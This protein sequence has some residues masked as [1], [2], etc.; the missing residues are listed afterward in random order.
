[1]IQH[2]QLEAKE[3]IDGAYANCIGQEAVKRKMRNAFGGLAHRKVF[4]STL[5]QS[6][7]GSGKT[8]FARESMAIIGKIR[9]RIHG[10]TEVKG[11]ELNGSE[12]SSKSAF[13]DIV[14]EK[15]C[16]RV[17]VLFVDEIHAASSKIVPILLTILA[18]NKDN[19][20]RITHDGKEFV[21]DFR[22]FSFLAA[23]TEPQELFPALRDRLREVNLIE[24]KRCELAEIIRIH[25]DKSAAI[26][27]SA[28]VEMAGH[29]RGNARSAVNMASDISDYCINNGIEFH[30]KDI[31]PFMETVSIY[32]LGL[33]PQEI[34]ILR[35]LS[36]DGHQ[37][38]KSLCAKT[39]L[40]ARAQ[41]D[42]EK[43][44]L[45]HGLMTIENDRKITPKGIEYLKGIGG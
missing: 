23:T 27:E 4:A 25:L 20:T 43:F 28:L 39:G 12:L 15:I 6:E 42:A 26:E 19:V 3:I 11:I 34:A 36:R 35:Y 21:F 2:I 32:P 10:E 17:C 5:F 41:Q 44:L 8:L 24:P 22:K 29:C 18:P 45:R 37:Q 40:T 1:M 7:R 13:F 30:K 14:R 38:M 31:E 16:D 9:K 33:M